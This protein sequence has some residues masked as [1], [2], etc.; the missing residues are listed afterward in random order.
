MVVSFFAGYKKKSR[1]IFQKI[2]SR[3]YRSYPVWQGFPMGWVQSQPSLEQRG[4][5]RVGGKPPHQ[6]TTAEPMGI[7]DLRVL[8]EK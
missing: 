1:L 3:S 5:R 8:L 4:D 2:I 6:F 7:Q